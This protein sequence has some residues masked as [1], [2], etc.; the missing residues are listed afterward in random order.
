MGKDP[1]CSCLGLSPGTG[2]RCPSGRG[3]GLCGTR[4]GGGRGEGARPEQAS[5]GGAWASSRRDWSACLHQHFLCTWIFN[6]TRPFFYAK[7]PPGG[8]CI[9]SSRQ[10]ATVSPAPFSTAAPLGTPGSSRPRTLTFQPVPARQPQGAGRGCPGRARE[11][12]ASS[13]RRGA[14]TLQGWFLFTSNLVLRTGTRADAP[15]P[16]GEG[17]A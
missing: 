3:G 11:S 14:Q 12:K 1:G 5:R 7:R 17:R 16:P 9:T 10:L 6:P 13:G 2:P 4:G 8:H 15:L